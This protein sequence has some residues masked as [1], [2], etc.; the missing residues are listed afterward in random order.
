MQRA[1]D[2]LAQAQ[3]PLIIVGDEVAKTDALH[4]LVAVAEALGAPVFAET[5]PNT[6][7]FPS[8]HPLYQGFMARTQRGVRSV[9]QARM[10]CSR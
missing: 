6:T 3:H 7:S 8:D 10:W 5:V 2:I 9:L 4:E 1:A